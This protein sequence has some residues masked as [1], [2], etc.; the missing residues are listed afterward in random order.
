M[1]FRRARRTP[2]N[3]T[4]PGNA[5]GTS[6][7]RA[8]SALSRRQ[9]GFPAPGTGRAASA[10]AFPPA[11]SDGSPRARRRA[12]PPGAARRPQRRLL[13]FAEATFP[14]RGRVSPI[15]A[16]PASDGNE[17]PPPQGFARLFAVS[18][19]FLRRSAFPRRPG[20]R[21]PPRV[22][23]TPAPSSPAR[24]QRVRAPSGIDKCFPGRVSFP[25]FPAGPARLFSS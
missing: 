23:D 18:L 14:P 13:S 5:A 8:G 11:G 20:R 19:S 3:I 12:S 22:R 25:G 2:T 7:F 24:E 17:L 10:A 6:I 15:C 9:H 1:S 4:R 21:R 16:D